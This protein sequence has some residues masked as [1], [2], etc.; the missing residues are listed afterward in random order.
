[1]GPIR[2]RFA[3][4]TVLSALGGEARPASRVGLEPAGAGDLLQ[5]VDVYRNAGRPSGRL[6]SSC[7]TESERTQLSKSVPGGMS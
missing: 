1:M 6:L 2:Y 3:I 5:P 7:M 4:V